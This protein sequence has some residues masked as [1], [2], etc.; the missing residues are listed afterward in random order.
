MFVPVNRMFNTTEESVDAAMEVLHILSHDLADLDKP[1]NKYL[2]D[3]LYK[4]FGVMVCPNC[5]AT[6]REIHGCKTCRV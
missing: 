3:V 2:L 1:E 5:G 6:I 4:R